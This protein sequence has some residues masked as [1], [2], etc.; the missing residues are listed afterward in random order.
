MV[1]LILSAAFC[2]AAYGF[3]E[4]YNSRQMRRVQLEAQ[5]RR[6][7]LLTLRHQEIIRNREILKNVKG[8]SDQVIRHGLE[9]NNWT[10]YDVNVEGG[11]S[12]DAAHKI[13][14]QCS[15]SAA[16]YYWPISMEIRASDARASS[17]P[18]ASPSNTMRKGDVQLTI[19]GQFVA[20]KQ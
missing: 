3:F 12:Y 10:F 17:Q 5:H 15:D 1:T 20:R 14:R 6:L 19:K 11:F 18:V 2:A 7:H 16:A 13:I 4:D 9:R 8:F